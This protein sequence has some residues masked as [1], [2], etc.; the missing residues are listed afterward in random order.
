[1]END[2]A[3]QAEEKIMSKRFLLWTIIVILISG[4][5]VLLCLQIAR[6]NNILAETRA[7]VSQPFT[8]RQLADAARKRLGPDAMLPPPLA[9]IELKRPVRLA[10][11]SLGLA[12]DEQNGRLSDLILTE[13]SGA[14]GLNLVDR[15]SLE[16]VLRELN[17]SWS[18]L[19][20]AKDAVRAGKLLKAD[21]FLL[22]T[23]A[24]ING[25]NSIVIRVVDARTGIL[26]DAGV[27][28]TGQPLT[29]LAKD[30]AAFL[31]QSRQNAAGAKT[32]VFLAIGTFEDLS[33]NNRQAGF[34]TQL[35]GYLTAAYQ[36]SGVTLLE[37]EYVETLLQEVHL[38]LAGLTEESATNAPAPMQSAY[39]LASGSYQSF[40]TTNLE[41]EVALDVQRIFGPTK[42]VTLRGLAGE[43]VSRQV[44]QAIDG[45]LNQNQGVVIPSRTSEIRAQMSFGKDL[46]RIDRFSTVAGLV[47]PQLSDPEC[48][49]GNTGNF[50]PQ[51]GLKRR[52]NLQ[53][54]IR[55]FETVLLLDPGNRE[56]KMYLAACLRSPVIERREEARH[57]YREIIEAQLQDK[58]TGLAQRALVISFQ[59][60]FGG[61]DSDEK[62][63][64]FASAAR[65]SISSPE[66][67]F[68]S[69][70]AREAE[71]DATIQRGQ[72]P[73]AQSLAEQRMF[74]ALRAYRKDLQAKQT[75]DSD[76]GMS[77]FV[78]T[79]GDDRAAAVQ[80]L[81]EL[82]PKVKS[83]VPELEPYFL[84]DILTFQQD[85]NAPVVAQF[86]RELALLS[87]H[88]AQMLAPAQFWN[89][90][91]HVCD[92]SF[93]HK[94]Y[95]LAAQVIEGEQRA[96]AQGCPVPNLYVNNDQDRI[97]LAY[98]YLGTEHW[99]QAR[100]IFE[101][102]SNQ[103][104]FMQ[105][106]GPWG[107][108]T[109]VLTGKE[110]AFCAEKLGQPSTRDPREF[111][112]GKACFCLCSPAAYVV[113]DSGLWIGIDNRL[114]RLDF[115]LKTNLAVTLPKDSATPVCC[116]CP[117]PSSVWI[118]T[119]GEGLI[120]FDKT[121]RQCRLLTEQDGLLMNNISCLDL[122]G[123]MLWIGYGHRA[124]VFYGMGISTHEGG[125]GRLDLST[126]QF[127]SFT[128]SLEDRT[129]ARLEAADKPTR[130]PVIAL[131][132]GSEN[133]VWFVTED[134]GNTRLRHFR[135]RD[136]LWEAGPQTASSLAVDQKRL[137]L[138][139]YWSYGGEDKSGPLGVSILDFKDGQW[140]NLKVAGG[141]P[142][143]AVSALAP[144]GH[145]LWVGGKGYIAL[146][147]L[148]QD[149]VRKFARVPAPAVDQIQIG[150]G[151]LW[152]FYDWH[153]HRALLQNI[154]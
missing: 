33:V 72:S 141:L 40:E 50:I 136:N 111:D 149:K 13:L 24:K 26:R 91:R 152:A 45:F 52:R 73:A 37:R 139:Q 7:R 42:Q 15:Q 107:G 140:R 3:S 21:W 145:D 124:F 104:V 78:E 30:V 142:S 48:F 19:V 35:R 129:T 20:R 76:M 90:L 98:A 55:A 14:Q 119:D 109:M 54:A 128:P 23:G 85:T 121:S 86:R 79:F 70:Q 12:D 134:V 154:R 143:G 92:W 43:P 94:F 133:D 17:L 36:G 39:W 63:R 84:S 8:E 118:G 135:P 56:A 108:L 4:A 146:V 58:W 153:L 74:D 66:K 81:V 28:S 116:L 151:C 68:Y 105:N 67:D 127:S 5:T 103:S 22:G 29:Q 115:E 60:R 69:K 138:G 32:P 95:A 6:S 57:Y 97:A 1:M 88:P 126:R 93:R 41:V 62:A 99:Q 64:W 31:R 59:N 144:D 82:L 9:P 106:R 101:S 16:M 51:I 53:E 77:P 112:M 71:A 27:F 61:I 49:D 122:A 148:E 38:D 100:D 132:N 10:L 2:P 34:P 125:L 44:K 87:E 147:D 117:T 130:R 83:L 113:D 96:L 25:T 110:A 47:Y 120:E 65:Q 75:Y 89:H 80:R 123:D 46:S 102:F 131:A 18:G 11:G 150:G 137:F 114:L